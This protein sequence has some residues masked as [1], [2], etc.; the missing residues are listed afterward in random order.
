VT[1]E[2]V[3]LSSW[4]T[5]SWAKPSEFGLS[6]AWAASPP[7]N[8][9]VKVQIAMPLKR[10]DLPHKSHTILGETHLISTKTYYFRHSQ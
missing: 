9:T 10:I 6:L 5:G 7:V 3:T 8:R 4:V 1:E 2:V